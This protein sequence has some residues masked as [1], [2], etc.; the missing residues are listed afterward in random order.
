MR[1]NGICLICQPGK[2]KLKQTE[3]NLGTIEHN[4][5]LPLSSKLF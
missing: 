3:P 5:S 1:I 4:D 2:M